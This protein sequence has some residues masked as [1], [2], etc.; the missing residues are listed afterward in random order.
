M[1][2]SSSIWYYVVVVKSTVKI[3]SILVAFL[4]NMNFTVI[5]PLKSSAFFPTAVKLDNKELFDY[6]KIV[7]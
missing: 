6:P 2:S 4:D 7:P 1:K 5:T 3:S